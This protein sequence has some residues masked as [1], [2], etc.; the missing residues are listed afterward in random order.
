ESLLT[1]DKNGK[2]T[3]DL[4]DRLAP[5]GTRLAPPKKGASDSGPAGGP[6][7]PAVVTKRPDM[8]AYFFRGVQRPKSD[9]GP[10]Q[11]FVLVTFEDGAARSVLRADVDLQGLPKPGGGTFD[12]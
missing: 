5:D 11:L 8:W 12:K 6:S 10:A 4:G 3:F 2:W 1:F 7:K 9:E